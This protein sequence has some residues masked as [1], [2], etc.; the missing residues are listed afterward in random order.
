MEIYTNI[1]NEE[2]HEY[3]K[4]QQRLNLVGM[5]FCGV[6]IVLGIISLFL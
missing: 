6:G 2:Y 3:L 4:S 1:S 5:I